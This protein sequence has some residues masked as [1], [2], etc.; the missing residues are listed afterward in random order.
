MK[1]INLCSFLVIFTV[2][3][4]AQNKPNP[5]STELWEPVPP[6]V[7]PGENGKPS[8]DAIVLFDGTNLTGWE[9]LD[10]NPADWIVADG[11]FTV[12]SHKVLIEDNKTTSN[13]IRTKRKFG[14][15]Q[16]H[17]EWRSPAEV[18]GDG[19]NR[20][21][22]GIG[23]QNHYELQV[24]DCYD[25]KTY[26]NG[27]TG[28]MYKQSI[29]LVN[30]CKKPGEWQT[31]DIIHI[32][33]RFSEN[34]RVIVP[35]HITVLLNG[36]AVQINTEIRGSTAFVGLPKNHLHDLKEPISLQDHGCPVSY[37]NIWIREL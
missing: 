27:M 4:T 6:V 11:C 34:G 19:Q 30:A 31:Y 33:P 2:V 20:G 3:V 25:N 22:S 1:K 8:S 5:E 24:L 7:T 29:P 10:G 37:R 26:V 9:C 18:K 23:M 35:G 32:A 17:I 16:L 21:N 36:I 15:C 12:N 14:D 28:S 13:S